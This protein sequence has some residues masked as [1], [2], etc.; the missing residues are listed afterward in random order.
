MKK[1]SRV[2]SILLLAVLVLGVLSGCALVGRNAAKYRSATAF[3]V[4]QQ[5]VTIGKVIDTF[6]NYYNQYYSYISQGYVSA[7]N[8][9]EMAMSGL[10]T[11]YIKLD[12]YVS[13]EANVKQATD[14][15][16]A[17]GRYLT[18][19][20][21]QYVVS[22]VKY[23]IFTNYDSAVE[24]E[25]KKTYTLN[26]KETDDTSRDFTKYDDLGGA[27]SYNAYERNQ[28]FVNEDM[29]DYFND[30]YAGVDVAKGNSLEMYKYAAN[31]ANAAKRVADYNARIDKTDDEDIEDITVA[32]YIEWQNKIFK[33]YN[34]SIETSYGITIEEFVKNQIEDAIVSSIVSLYN[35]NVASAIEQ[36]EGL[37]KAL[38]T[39]KA[40]AEA[41]AAAQNVE[42]QIKD[43]FVSFV[44]SLADGKYV[45]NI[46]SNYNGQYIF[47]KNILVPFS[48]EQKALLSNVEKQL[49][50]STGDEYKAYREKLAA[51]IVA[52]NFLGEKDEDGNYPKVENLF[53]YEGG[54][55]VIN[56]DGDL[57]TNFKA[58]GSVTAESGSADDVVVEYMKKYNTDTA[59]HTAA[60]DYVVRTNAPDDYTSSW[61]SEFVDAANAAKA[62]GVGHYAL[63]VSTYGV[64]IVY[65]VKDVAVQTFDFAAN[66]LNTATAEYKL[67]KT[68]YSSESSKLLEAALEEL[69]EQYYDTGKKNTDGKFVVTS[70][71]KITFSKMFESFL[72]EQGLTFDFKKSIQHEHED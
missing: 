56:P 32:Q 24:E 59:Q 69:Q 68:Y 16:Y 42:F 10:Y 53:K 72:S 50:S 36:G 58:D 45:Y 8:L 49:G 35:N 52:D 22:Y 57:G 30:Y 48:D 25:I 18:A 47:V 55:L 2:I 5:N 71:G 31:D 6:N 21:L 28:L 1:A 9:I 15:G 46:P 34:G 23:L 54:K 38:D 60:Y 51:E 7:D 19:E 62:L 41:D 64:H 20:Q 33:R 14:G 66:R 44:E 70:Q 3:T 4:G 12:A 37:T 17:Y 43:N 13:D 63:C 27:T 61:V 29:T 67:F 11:Q 65:Y 40:N 26:D 39:L